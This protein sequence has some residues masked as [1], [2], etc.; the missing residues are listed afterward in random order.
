MRATAAALTALL[1]AAAAPSAALAEPPDPLARLDFLLGEWDMHNVFTASGLGPGGAGVGLARY[2]RAL[3]D[4]WLVYDSELDI[5]GRGPYAVHGAVSFD[6]ALGRYRAW[7]FNSLG[8]AIEYTGAWEGTRLV[9]DAVRREA[10]RGARVSY[11]PR[12]DGSVVLRSERERR[13]GTGYETY[14]EARLTRAARAGSA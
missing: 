10:G 2:R 12:A 5:P 8:V 14:F 4:A 3:G 9:F 1:A 11:E 13:D 6:S 7:A